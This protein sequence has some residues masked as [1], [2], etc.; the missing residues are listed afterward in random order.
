MST[1]LKKFVTGKTRNNQ[2]V[3]RLGIFV[4]FALP[5]F[6]LELM[7][8]KMV[9]S[10]KPWTDFIDAINIGP[11]F[12]YWGFICLILNSIFLFIIL[13]QMRSSRDVRVSKDDSLGIE[14]DSSKA[15]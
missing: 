4:V 13:R 9:T 2:S 12:G 6:L 3:T 10:G 8:V 5:S 1:N 15:V 11:Y 14:K 7:W